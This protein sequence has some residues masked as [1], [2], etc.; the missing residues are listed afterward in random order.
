[1]V[2]AKRIAK[3]GGVLASLWGFVAWLTGILVSLAVGFG[4]I[5][6]T[7]TIPAIHK[8]IT[9]TAGYIVVILVI[10]GALLAVIDKLRR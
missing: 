5:S 9:I 10:I 4:M 6:E 1:M 3:S 2:K 7:L 8:M